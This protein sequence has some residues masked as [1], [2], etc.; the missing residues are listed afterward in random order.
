MEKGRSLFSKLF[1]TFIMAILVFVS[2]L[3]SASASFPSQVGPIQSGETLYVGDVFF[4]VKYSGDYYTFCTSGINA[5][6]PNGRVCKIINPSDWSEGKQAGVAA[7]INEF[8]S[9]NIG[10][11]FAEVAINSFLKPGSVSAGAE[12]LQT[13]KDLV[14]KAK[15]AETKASSEFSVVLSTNSLSFTESNGYYVSN[16]VSVSDKNNLLEIKVTRLT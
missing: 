14:T 16:T 11:G 4:P 1:F 5:G 10:F 2:G 8:N 6:V 12:S 9:G 15:K 13:V 7:I 3:G